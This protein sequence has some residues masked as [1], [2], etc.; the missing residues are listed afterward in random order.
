MNYRKIHNTQVKI[1]VISLK[2]FLFK[3]IIKINQKMSYLLEKTIFSKFLI[4][5][6]KKIPIFY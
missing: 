5:I 6:K 1:N 2:L 4:V 3:L